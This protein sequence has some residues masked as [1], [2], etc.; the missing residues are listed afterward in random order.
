LIYSRN[1][2]FPAVGV[3]AADQIFKKT[4]VP[5]REEGVGENAQAV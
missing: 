3:S 4:D 1:I 5:A 2:F